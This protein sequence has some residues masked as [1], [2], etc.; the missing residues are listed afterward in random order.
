[1]KSIQGFDAIKDVIID[2]YYITDPEGNIVEYNRLF[3][4][5]FPRQVARKLKGKKIQEVMQIDKDVSAMAIQQRMHVRLDEITARIPGAEQEEFRFIL[6]AIP[7]FEGDQ[8]EGTL[9]LMRNVT[10]EALIQVKYQEML[11][12]EE[13]ARQELKNELAAKTEALL[14]LSHKYFM[15]KGQVQSKRQGRLSPFILTPE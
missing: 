11:E 5:L 15:L 7:L 10:D 13:R 9:V 12:R 2:A 4:M 6:S 3:Y 14:E 8:L 1:M